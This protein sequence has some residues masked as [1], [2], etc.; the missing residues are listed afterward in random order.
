M[1]VHVTSGLMATSALSA[2][3]NQVGVDVKLAMNDRKLM[4]LLDEGPVKLIVVDLQTKGMDVSELVSQVREK[5]AGVSMI[6]YAQH[7][8]EDLLAEA[9]QLGFDS[10]MTRGQ[11][12]RELPGIVA[13]AR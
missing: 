6:A 11:F 2:T 1:I 9:Q 8:H 5:A 10:V 4:K 7:V 3:A 13:S 12:T